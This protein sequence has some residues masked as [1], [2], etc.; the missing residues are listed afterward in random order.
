MF[1]RIFARP[2]RVYVWVAYGLAILSIIVSRLGKLIPYGADLPTAVVEWAVMGMFALSYLMLGA[3]LVV[4][5][6]RPHSTFTRHSDKGTRMA[7]FLYALGGL[8]AL[9]VF[10]AFRIATAV[11]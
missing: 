7:N 6:L 9:H 8:I 2:T 11:S 10:V 5:P 4:G 1:R 3:L